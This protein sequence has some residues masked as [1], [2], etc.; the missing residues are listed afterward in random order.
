MALLGMTIGMSKEEIEDAEL[1]GGLMGSLERSLKDD[2]LVLM[3]QSAGLVVNQMSVVTRAL[4]SKSSFV[5]QSISS[6][7]KGATQRRTRESG[8]IGLR[9]GQRAQ[10]VRVAMA[11]VSSTAEG[12]IA[13]ETGAEDEKA[14]SDHV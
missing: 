1:G 11:A 14:P 2:P 3:Q 13:C 6:R 10:N 12:E 9:R 8:R 4:H 5:S 7:D